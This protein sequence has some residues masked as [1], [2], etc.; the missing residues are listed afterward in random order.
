[1]GEMHEKP[2]HIKILEQWMK[3]YRPE[4]LFDANGRFKPE[5]AELAP[6]GERRM[7]ANP[8]GNGGL[9]L[10]D[11][12]M[13]DF[14]KYAVEVKK[15]GATD[16]EATRVM[17]KF[18]RDVMKLN[19]ESKNFRLFSPDENNSN[20]WQDALEVTNRAWMAETFRLRRPSGARRPRDGD[21]ERAPV[22]GLARRLSAHGTPRVLLLLRGVHSHHRFDVQPAREMVEGLQSHSVAAAHRVAQLPAQFA[23]LAA[24]PQRL[25]APGSRLHRSRREQEGRGRARLSAA[26][27]ELPALRHRPLPAQP[28]LHQR[29][30]R[31]Q[32][33]RAGLADD[34]RGDQ[35]L[36]RRRRHLGMGQ[37]R[38]GRRAGR[39]DG[40]LRRCAHAR[41]ARGRGS[42]PPAHARS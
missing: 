15:P 19:M 30:R 29:R 25:L 21:V 10:R 17:G 6:K 2:G 8:H 31:R 34:G 12:R 24:G 22:P 9:L 16:A 40:V 33:A 39:G 28:Q 41:N 37:Q 26:R 35:A 32:T 42:H 4:E 27:R 18:L 3:S 7:S 13:P 23:R 1:M 36:H 5:L 38:Q 14:R 20:R 11:L